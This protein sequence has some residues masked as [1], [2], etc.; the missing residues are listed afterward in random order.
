MGQANYSKAQASLKRHRQVQLS[1][2]Q[3]EIEE[4]CF[5]QKFIGEGGEVEVMTVSPWGQAGVS[6]C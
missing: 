1:R 2:F 3:E 6:A 5:E 4:G